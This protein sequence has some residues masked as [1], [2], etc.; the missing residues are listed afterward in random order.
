MGRKTWLYE[1]TT[2]E[3]SATAATTG[4][5]RCVVFPKRIPSTSRPYRSV[6]RCTAQRS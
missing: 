6:E 4:A 5:M 2:V 1:K 3:K